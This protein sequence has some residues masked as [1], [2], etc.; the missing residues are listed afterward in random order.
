MTSQLP[1]YSERKITGSFVAYKQA[2]PFDDYPAELDGVDFDATDLVLELNLKD[3]QDI[4]NH[5]ADD[6]L[7][8][9]LA[10]YHVQDQNPN[11]G[12]KVTNVENSILE[13]FNV[14][15]GEDITQAMLDQARKAH[16]INQAKRYKVTLYHTEVRSVEI[17]VDADNVND[18]VQRA[19]DTAAD[20]DLYNESEYVDSNFSSGNVTNLGLAPRSTPAARPKP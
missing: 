11:D 5:N 10:P 13:F 3:I 12:F 4:A 14:E 20:M 18:A 8:D 9:E 19:T 15:Q 1:D 17:E 16:H 7:I 6:A 2:H